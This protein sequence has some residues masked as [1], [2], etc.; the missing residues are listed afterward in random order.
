MIKKRR[1]LII[2][3]FILVVA[4]LVIYLA[5][6]ADSLSSS[7]NSGINGEL[8][9]IVLISI[10]LGFIVGV[11]GDVWARQLANKIGTLYSRLLRSSSSSSLFRIRRKLRIPRISGPSE[12]FSVRFVSNH[13]RLKNI[14]SGLG[15]RLQGDLIKSGLSLSPYALAGRYLFYSMLGML[16]AIPASISLA[17][18]LKNPAFLALIVLVPVVI[19]L[20]PKFKLSSARGERN[21]ALEDE[22]PF[23]TMYASVMQMV[24]LSLYNSFVNVI[25]R[26][27]FR[28]VEKDAKLIQ[29][30]EMFFDRDPVSAL[31]GVGRTHPNEKMKSLILGYTSQLRSGGDVSGYLATKAS[32]FLN[33]MKFRWKS[34]ANSVANIGEMM[35][36]LFFILPILVLVSA[37]I[38]PSSI[39]LVDLLTIVLI[40]F[41][42]V[43]ALQVISTMQP[44]TYDVITVGWKMPVV[45][46]AISALLPYHSTNPGSP[47]LLG[48]WG[49]PRSTD[50]YRRLSSGKLE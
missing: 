30:N 32:D 37:F 3:A 7:P 38:S 34:Y 23:F 20:A 21:R 39:S 17:Y 41:L 40:P 22:L 44:K 47:L 18:L 8:V 29:R 15:E 27:V 14:A 10:S 13:K 36:S 26:G 6:L 35:V 33:D 31:E 24:G 49:Q 2:S 5:L 28:Y 4:A 50:S 9:T 45:A 16:L 1:Q 46:G 11:L 12:N 48:S 42:S 43:L 19:I 25:G